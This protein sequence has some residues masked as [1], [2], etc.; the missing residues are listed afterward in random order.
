MSTESMPGDED[1]EA[2]EATVSWELG[3]L[4]E[5]VE[6]GP[7]PYDRLLAGGRRRLRRRRLLTGAA[8]AGL[9]VAV[10][11][12]GTLLGGAGTTFGGYGRTG[13][14]SV[15]AVSS[16]P[17]AVAPAGAGASASP[18]ASA[19][20]GVT[21]TATPSVSPVPSGA[22]RD[23]FTPLRVKI[24]EGT[25]KGHALEAWIALWPAASTAEDGLTQDRLIQ[26][27][28]RTVDPRLPEQPMGGAIMPWT[29]H[30]DRA[31]VY[32][33][34]DGKR[35]PGDFVDPVPAA[36]GTA[37]DD[38]GAVIGGVV[39]NRVV[40]TGGSPQMVVVKVRPEVERVVVRLRT[41]GSI[42]A[43][44]VAVGDSPVR[45]YAVIRS[46][47]STNNTAVSY[48]ADGSVLRTQTTWW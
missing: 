35:Q 4:A 18:A 22:A 39:L 31:D 36:G 37:Q 12:A 24:N 10:G 27:E 6:A 48:A 34:V 17:V 15:A 14:A 7:V 8:V 47:G 16:A 29:P 5:S 9:V 45:W 40:D 26:Q 42:E 13:D 41:G 11:G 33:V 43:E 44:P 28:R 23:P 2:A 32:L 20:M 25:V 19:A 46:P 30:T 21:P 38:A 1:V 3:E